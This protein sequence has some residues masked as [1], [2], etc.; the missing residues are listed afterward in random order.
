MKFRHKKA[1]SS[2]GTAIMVLISVVLGGLVLTGVIALIDD[3]VSPTMEK[4]FS[5]QQINISREVEEED[6]YTPGD[7]NKDGVV[8]E[9]D[10]QYFANFMAGVDG[11]SE[12]SIDVADLNNDNKITIQDLYIL[13]N[14]VI[15]SGNTSF[16]LGD[17]NKDGVIDSKDYEY[18]NRFVSNWDG[19]SNPDLSVC[20]INGDG[21][22][23]ETDLQ[24]LKAML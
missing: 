7:I 20:D 6:K 3:N 22:V 15:T 2:I 23:D 19:Y 4:T 17:T 24:L 21:V 1:E 13:R 9:I 16:E 10:Y 18:L 5:D 12:P 8:N 11:Y 14:K